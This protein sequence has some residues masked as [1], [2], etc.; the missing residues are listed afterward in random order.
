MRNPNKA[1]QN[2]QWEAHPS[3]KTIISGEKQWEKKIESRK[4][5]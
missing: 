3:G 4:K 2:G 5:D 1:G